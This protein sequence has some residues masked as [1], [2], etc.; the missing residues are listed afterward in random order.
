M[1]TLRS[2]M[3]LSLHRGVAA[4]VVVGCALFFGAALAPA[5]SAAPAAVTSVQPA[6]TAGAVQAAA[7]SDDWCGPGN[8]NW[9]SWWIPDHWGKANFSGSCLLHDR[10]YS[11]ISGWDRLTC[12]QKLKGNM[13][14]DCRDAYGVGVKRSSCYAVASAYY[15]VVRARAKSNYQGSGSNA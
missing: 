8:G 6:V 1:P 10:C 13:R 9:K 12:D 14:I 5:A 11:T 3:H 7:A 4:I 15:K 2:R